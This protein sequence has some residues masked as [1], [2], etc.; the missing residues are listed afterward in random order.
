MIS[1]CKNHGF[2]EPDWISENNTTKLIFPGITHQISSEGVNEGV[3]EGVFE[4]IEGVNEG[5]KIELMAILNMLSNKPLQR[6]NEIAEQ[7]NKGISTVERYLRILK[8]NGL[9]EFVGA[10]KTGGYKLK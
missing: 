6:T 1:E 9:I 5:V 2:L 10:P 3:N 7:V 4:S 8:D